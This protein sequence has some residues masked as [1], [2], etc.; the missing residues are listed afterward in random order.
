[1]TVKTNNQTNKQTS[2]KGL[3]VKFCYTHKLLHAQF[4][5]ET[6]YSAADGCGCKDPST[7]IIQREFKLKVS[8]GSLPRLETQQKK[9]RKDCK[10]QR[11]WRAKGEHKALNR[12]SRIHIGS[13]WSDKQRAFMALHQVP[14][15]YAM[16]GSLIFLLLLITGAGVSL[17]LLPDLE[18]FSPT[19]LPC[20][21]Q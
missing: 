15:V 20:S 14:C 18:T 8:T 13:Q 2:M 21:P 11:E 12:L 10:S 9:G 3:S 16:A 19:G 17:T 1:M 6:L 5:L 7:D 4:L